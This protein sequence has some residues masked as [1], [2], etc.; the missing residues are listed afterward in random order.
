[1]YNVSDIFKEY[2]V[3]P[4]REFEVK[5]MVDSTEYDQTKVVEFYIDD[6]I[7][8]GDDFEIGTVLYSKLTLSVKTE[9]YAPSSAKIVPNIR[10]KTNTGYTEWVPLGTF[11]IDTRSYKNGVWTFVCCDL[12]ARTQNKFNSNL[13]YPVS[14]QSVWNEMMSMLGMTSHSSVVINPNYEIPYKLEDITYREMMGYIASAHGASVK[15]SRA[16]EVKFV[17]MVGVPNTAAIDPSQYVK[18][19]ITDMKV[20]TRIVLTYNED[21]ET[22]EIGSGSGANTLKIYN[23]FMTE[24]ML[25]DLYSIINNFSYIPFSMVWKGA[26][27]I[28][29][30]D[31]ITIRILKPASSW[32]PSFVMTNKTS[33]KGGLL[34]TITA[35][36]PSV[37]KSEFNYEGNLSKTIANAVQK[38]TPYYGVTIGRTNGLNIQRSDGASRAVFNSDELSMYANGEQKLYFDAQKG[39]FV[40]NGELSTDLFNAL[41]ANLS[42]VVSNTNVTQILTAGNAT[43]AE[44]TVDRLDTGIAKIKNYLN[45]DTS[46][47]HY[48]RDYAQYS[49]YITASTDGLQEEQVTDRN[50]NP[51]YWLDDTHMGTTTD[52]TDYPVMSYVYTETIKLE[53]SFDPND[54]N[55]TPKII[56]GAGTG[57]GNNGKGFIWKDANGLTLQYIKEDGM[58]VSISLGEA[59]LNLGNSV[60]F[61][62]VS[63]GNITA[64]NIGGENVNTS[65]VNSENVD[66]TN[67]TAA[68]VTTETLSISTSISAPSNATSNGSLRNIHYSTSDPTSLDGNNGDIWLKYEV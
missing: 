5:A 65:N 41:R 23:P 57:S 33:F 22:L 9:E 36:S 56:L 55:N 64:D 11:Y 50:G 62:S 10:L 17:C 63:A 29:C 2:I 27:Y 24:E 4:D 68:N 7:I 67:V 54:P 51:L 58:G 61:Q 14:M 13:T 19:D 37:L 16:E 20:I 53:I 66:C 28:D 45:S 44:L 3:K 12:L 39:N 26:P 8:S 43:I 15:L 1:M 6:S 40:F 46:D 47:I 48:K 25:S 21:G 34:S 38:D 60:E 42:V 59:G 49:Q 30:G 52:E 18:V 35:P 32:I 31:R